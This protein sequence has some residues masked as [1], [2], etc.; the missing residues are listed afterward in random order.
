MTTAAVP[1]SFVDRLRSA[2]RRRPSSGA[3]TSWG[4]VCRRAARRSWPGALLVALAIVPAVQCWRTGLDPLID[5]GRELYV[6]WRLAEGE[7]LYRD[8]AYFNGPLSP[9]LNSLWFRWFGTSLGTL[10]TANLAIFAATAF[11]ASRLLLRIASRGAAV[12]ATAVLPLLLGFGNYASVANYNFITPYSHEMTHGL[13][14]ALLALAAAWRIDDWGWPAVVA[15]GACVGGTL[16]TKPELALAAGA[17]VVA[18]AVLQ[19]IARGTPVRRLVLA[20]GVAALSAAGVALAA[21]AW[22][23]AA[24]PW[25]EAVAHTT[26]AWRM[27]ADSEI[28]QLDFYRRCLGTYDLAASCEQLAVSLLLGVQT[29]GAAYLVGRRFGPKEL[30]CAAI[31]AAQGGVWRMRAASLALGTLAGGASLT[32]GFDW[33]LVERALP[34]WLL[35]LGTWQGV[36]LAQLRARSGGGQTTHEAAATAAR[37]IAWCVFAL[38]L[39]AK[40]VLFARVTHYGFALA[41][42]ALAAA[43]LAIFDWAPRNSEG[44]RTWAAALPWLAAPLMAAYLA[45]YQLE[46][47]T[48]VSREVE[49]GLVPGDRFYAGASAASTAYAAQLVAERVAPGETLAVL[50]EGVMLNYLA[51]RPSSTRYLTWMPPEV[52]HFGEEAMLADLAARPPDWIVVAPRRLEEYGQADFGAGYCEATAAWI[53]ANYAPVEQWAE[54]WRLLR[55]GKP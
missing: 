16:L 54:R 49:L 23:A 8:V 11:V 17:G 48:H 39:L 55:R 19:G 21:T 34:A 53:E 47:S 4:D 31:P 3:Q 5:F 7:V 18:S 37:R 33:P 35:V 27:A 50:P 30:R 20:T 15:A 9:Y 1:R 22:L 14:L 28:R 46:Q 12:A 13:L 43:V 29:L 42:P 10:M 51:R 2:L 45:H 40:I 32:V 26:A 38:A 6:P 24:M 52:I 25:S 44:R 41:F 36:A